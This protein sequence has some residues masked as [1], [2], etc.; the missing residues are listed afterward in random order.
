MGFT[1]PPLRLK[2]FI[3][4]RIFKKSK[5]KSA[6]CTSEPPFQKAWIYPCI[7]FSMQDIK[8]HVTLPR[9]MS[10]TTNDFLCLYIVIIYITYSKTCVKRPL[11]KRPQIGFQDK[12]SLNAGQKYCRMLQGEHLSLKSLFCLFLSGR[13]TQVLLY[14][15]LQSGCCKTSIK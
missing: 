8:S 1:Y 12:L 15:V 2:Y 5:V 9:V 4:T 6:N 3:F 10:L 14:C 11:S 13:F 7:V